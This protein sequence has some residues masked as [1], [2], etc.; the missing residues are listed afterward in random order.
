VAAPAIGWST[1]ACWRKIVSKTDTP[2]GHRPLAD[3]ELDAV[4]GGMGLLGGIPGYSVPAPQL[5]SPRRLSD[6]ELKR[7]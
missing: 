2:D 6:I 4:S 1:L 3:S 5:P 7:P